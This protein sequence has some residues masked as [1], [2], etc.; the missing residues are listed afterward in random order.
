MRDLHSLAD[1]DDTAAA[2]AADME[3]RGFLQH[4]VA[5]GAAAA[6][7]GLLA[8]CAS[9]T[10]TAAAATPG[11]PAPARSQW[12]M[13]WTKKLGRYKTAYDSPEVMSGAALA[14]AASSNQGYKQALGAADSEVTPVLILRHTA[15]IMVLND[16]IWDRL[17]FG[18]SHKL[19]DPT[20][21]EPARRN[22]F[23][24][25]KKGDAH[26]MTGS[27]AGLDTLVAA[28]AIVLTCHRALSGVAYQLSRKDT[29]LTREAALAEVLRST[30]PGVYVMPNGI[31]A[32]SAAQDAGC[33][34]MRVV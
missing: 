8:G 30:L 6:G 7:A 29:A 17:A 26:T 24:N 5:A 11:S 16:A 31:F 23:I 21:G 28:G 3:R 9:G 4:L 33:H 27:S 32:V 2:G 18:E 34:Y 14:F 19:K 1:H 25:F 22:P 15:S 13:S 10:G 20:T 12:D